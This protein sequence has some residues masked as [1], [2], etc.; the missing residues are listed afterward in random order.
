MRLRRI[1]MSIALLLGF[2]AFTAPVVSADA[3]LQ[4][5]CSGA[6]SASSVCQ[7]KNQTTNPV[8][9]ANGIL[10]KTGRIVAIIAAIIAV[11]VIMAGGV[12]YITANG[13]SGKIATARNMIIYAAVGLIVIGIAGAIITLIVNTISTN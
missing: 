13:D 5:A 1:I 9:G 12:T 2:L 3:P 7:D 10:Y 8:T 4:D 11:F 6:G